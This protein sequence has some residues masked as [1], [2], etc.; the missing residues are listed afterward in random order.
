MTPARHARLS[1]ILDR[2]Q[3]D[4]TVLV[5]SLTKPH[6][7][8]AVVRSCDAVG[9]GELHAVSRGPDFN[10]HRMT[11]GGAR[12]YVRIRTHPDLDAAFRHLRAGGFRILAADL[13]PRAVDF[14]EV[15]YTLPTAILLGTELDGV[16]PEASAAADATVFIPMMGAVPSLNVSVAGAIILYEAQRQ[17]AEA[18]LYDRPRIDPE[19][20]RK[21][22]FEWGYRR[23]AEHCRQHHLPYPRLGPE[24]ELLDPIPRRRPPTP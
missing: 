16:T 1:A 20:R 13:D 9:V 6:N 2:R 19:L 15:D 23:L 3:P 14:R 18:G 5:D 24:G 22:L 21:L 10:P 12:R 7:V 17:R 11:S 4:L 8:S